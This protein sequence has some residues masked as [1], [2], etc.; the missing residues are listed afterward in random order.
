MLV[1]KSLTFN[2]FEQLILVVEVLNGTCRKCI[3]YEGVF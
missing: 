1:E 3:L 2:L